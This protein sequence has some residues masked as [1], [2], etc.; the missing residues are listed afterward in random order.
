MLGKFDY[1][2]SIRISKRW[3]PWL[4]TN[5]DVATGDVVMSWDKLKADLA[6]LSTAQLKLVFDLVEQ[7]RMR[8]EEDKRLGNP[9]SKYRW[10]DPRNMSKP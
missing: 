1:D 8:N 7:L 3:I 5:N 6:G 2:P 9:N 10:A 4:R